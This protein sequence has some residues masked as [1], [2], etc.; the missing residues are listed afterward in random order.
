MDSR[1]RSPLL[2]LTLVRVKEFLREPEAVFWTFLFPILLA[3]CLGLAFREKPPDRVPVGVVEAPGGAELRERLSRS[4][5]LVVRGYS[6][7]SGRE[8]LRAGAIS[9]LV[10]PGSP[11]TFRLDPTRPDARA[12][13]LE[14]DEALRSGGQPAPDAARVEEVREPGAR[15]IDFLMPGILGLNVMMAMWGLGFS[16]VSARLKNLLKR[17]V[18][19][20]MSRADYLLS[21]ILAR[22]LSLPLE[23]ALVLGFARLAYGITVRGSLAAFWALLLAGVFAFSGLGLLLASRTRTIEGLSGLMNLIM[24]PMWMVSG[25]FF[26][27]ERFPDS[28]LPL[29]RALPLTA[30][31]DGLRAVINQGAGLPETALPLF[32]LA[33]WGA[34]S[35]AVALRVFRWR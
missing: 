27:Y 22:L 34:V 33:A 12:A 11:P 17:L 10:V 13:R 8:A 35:F 29:I 19:T 16:I 18:A 30:L 23:V 31:N 2:E 6:E 4:P 32:C 20:P 3:V 28:A 25:V 5:G 1:P 21:Q 7:G 26:S 24:L 14:V 9:L 15:Y